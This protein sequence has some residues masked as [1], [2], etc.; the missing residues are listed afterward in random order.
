M[1]DYLRR[2]RLHWRLPPLLALRLI[3]EHMTI[4]AASDARDSDKA[5]AAVTAH[6]HRGA[7]AANGDVLRNRFGVPCAWSSE[8]CG[9]SASRAHFPTISA[10]RL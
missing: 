9:Q 1:Y 3:R 5:K 7:A 2:G 10:S 6:F 8:F 4:I